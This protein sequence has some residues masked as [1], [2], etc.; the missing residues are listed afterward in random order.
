[1]RL[2]NNRG[3]NFGG[4]DSTNNTGPK[5]GLVESRRE[6]YNR[7]FARQGRLVTLFTFANL[8]P[9]YTPTIG[10][11]NVRMDAYQLC[12][13]IGI[14]FNGSAP[15]GQTIASISSFLGYNVGGDTIILLD[16]LALPFV[17]TVIKTTQV[18]TVEMQETVGGR[19]GKGRM[20]RTNFIA[21]LGEI[22]MAFSDWMTGKSWKS[23]LPAN[24]LTVNLVMVAPSARSSKAVLN[25]TARTLEATFVGEDVV[26]FGA[27]KKTVGQIMASGFASDETIHDI[28]S[29]EHSVPFA[30]ALLK[31]VAQ[32]RIPAVELGIKDVKTFVANAA[33]KGLNKAYASW[34]DA[35]ADMNGVN[36]KI[37]VAATSI[38][39]TVGDSSEITDPMVQAIRDKATTVYDSVTTDSPMFEGGL[40]GAGVGYATNEMGF[41]SSLGIP[42]SFGTSHGFQ[43]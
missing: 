41:G 27:S 9:S 15:I 30:R 24:T 16:I 37:Q 19:R 29:N 23:A 40:V 33:R 8:T 32:G 2:N 6:M 26:I 10:E 13:R 1:M 14:R 21:S 7:L 18:K 12:N 34:N 38:K 5:S 22:K 20:E 11:Y 3:S 35:I 4:S 17:K 42:N 25:A 31:L 39:S 28:D 43:S 36:P